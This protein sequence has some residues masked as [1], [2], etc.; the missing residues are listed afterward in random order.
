MNKK[1]I[2][3]YCGRIAPNKEYLTKYGCKACDYRYW[4]EK[5]KKQTLD[6]NN[7]VWYTYS[8]EEKHI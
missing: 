5:Q 8:N 4:Q 7:R 2:C 6:T 1:L 3:K